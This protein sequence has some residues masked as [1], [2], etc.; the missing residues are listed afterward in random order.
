MEHVFYI[1]RHVIR[2]FV[3]ALLGLAQGRVVF[4]L[5]LPELF[6]QGNVFAYAEALIPEETGKQETAHA[7]VAI[8]KGMDRKKIAEKGTDG[9]ERIDLA[10]YCRV[11]CAQIV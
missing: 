10:I 7:A 1:R 2:A 4:C 5:R 11:G 8:I 3:P 9:D 6:L